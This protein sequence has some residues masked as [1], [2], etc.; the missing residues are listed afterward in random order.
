MVNGND[1]QKDNVVSTSKPSKIDRPRRIRS[2]KN[3]PSE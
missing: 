1:T 3:D 2:P